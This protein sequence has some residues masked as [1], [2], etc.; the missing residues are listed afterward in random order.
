MIHYEIRCGD[1]LIYSSFRSDDDSA[2]AEIKLAEEVNKAPTLTFTL[3]PG[4][5][6]ADLRVMRDEVTMTRNGEMIFRGRIRKRGRTFYNHVAYTAEGDI[7]YLHDIIRRPENAGSLT[8][9]AFFSHMVGYYNDRATEERRFTLGNVPEDLPGTN[10]E[11]PRGSEDYADCHEALTEGLD[12][13]NGGFLRTR[14]EQNPATGDWTHYIDFFNEPPKGSQRIEY[15][16]NILDLDDDEDGREICTRFIPLGKTVDKRR[17]TIAGEYLEDNV[18]AYG[19]IERTEDYPDAETAGTLAEWAEHDFAAMGVKEQKRAVKVKATDLYIIDGDEEPLRVGNTYEVYSHPHGIAFTGGE[20]KQLLRAETDPNRPDQ[21]FYW[22]GD[23]PRDSMRRIQADRRQAKETRQRVLREA[24]YTNAVSAG[25][26]RTSISRKGTSA[27]GGRDLVTASGRAAV[28]PEWDKVAL[29]DAGDVTVTGG[30]LTIGGESKAV[31]G[32]LD[33]TG[34]LNEKSRL[35]TANVTVTLGK[36]VGNGAYTVSAEAAGG[37]VIGCSVT[38]VS[39]AA[40]SVQLYA[41]G[42][43]TGVSV[44]VTAIG[45]E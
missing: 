38:G 16:R 10:T 42:K 19:V 26:G 31:T 6:A 7:A 41:I 37:A 20:R 34:S 27:T 28:S 17:L 35:Y 14:H 13:Y 36:A 11:R 12:L 5:P 23:V 39:G 33:I 32:T 29:L 4:H 18:A 43:P 24:S 30:S 25:G 45:T 22:F 9:G 2:A 44:S 1:R 21:C 8:D 15:A 40:V 3:T